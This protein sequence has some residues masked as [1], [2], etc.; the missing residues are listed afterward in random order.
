LSFHVFSSVLIRNRQ[1]HSR[2]SVVFIASVDSFVI[3]SCKAA[4]LVVAAG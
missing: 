2:E 4:G 3:H 1:G